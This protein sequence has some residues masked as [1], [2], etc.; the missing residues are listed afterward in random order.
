MQEFDK[1]PN[2]EPERLRKEERKE[3]MTAIPERMLLY[4]RILRGPATGL[5][6]Q[7]YLTHLGWVLMHR[8]KVRD[9]YEHDDYPGLMLVIATDRISVFDFVLSA[10]I[11]GKGESLTAISLFWLTQVLQDLPNHLVPSQENPKFNGAYD[12]F[13]KYGMSFPI[14]RALLVR[15]I[16][17]LDDELIFRRHLSA[18]RF[19]EYQR[20]GAIS[21]I[22]L[23][24][25][26]QR[27]EEFPDGAIFTPSTK[28]EVG[29]DINYSDVDVF[30]RK[31]GEKGRRLV[32]LCKEAY[33]RGYDEARKR[34]LVI[35]DTKFEGGDIIGD[36]VLTPDSSRYCTIE[37]YL[38]SQAVSEDPKALDKQFVRDYVDA[39]RSPFGGNGLKKLDPENPAHVGFAQS[40]ILPENVLTETHQIYNQRLP[41]LLFGMPL[42][43]F[44]REYMGVPV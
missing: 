35:L 24:P 14:E 44:Q 15:K 42:Q 22:A 3:V 41:E 17:M 27:W 5:T 10:I 20:E 29:H 39:F 1:I 34:G 43:Q 33:D 18:T 23:P 36:E 25:G 13:L 32:A 12:L 21:G 38:R 30:Y 26:L 37:E 8:G 40:I 7:A 4:P 31:H 2:N 16:Q 6:V 9:T 11:G 19:A 28:A